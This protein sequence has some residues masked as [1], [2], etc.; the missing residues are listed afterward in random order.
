LIVTECWERPVGPRALVGLVA[1]AIVLLVLAFEVAVRPVDAIGGSD[2]T[3]YEAYGSKILDGA[4]PYQDFPMEYPPGASLMFVL[5][6][7][8]VV[9]GGSTSGV[10]WSPP[11]VAA[12]RYYRGFTSL[13]LFLPA[14]TVVL[15]ALTL[16]AVRRPTRTVALSLA[17]IASSPL[18]LER[19]LTERFDVFPA[20]L[21]A[22]VLAVSVRGHYRLG[23]VLLG[24]SA[25]TKIYPALLLPLLVIVALRQRGA[26]EAI[27][28]AGAA[29]GTA[30]AVF[31]PFALASLPA[32]WDALTV[33]FRGGL[34]I[35]TFASSVLVMAGHAAEPLAAIGL[36]PPSPLTTQ[37]AGEGLNRA[38]LA[39]T[40]VEATKKVMN[41]LLAS[42]LCLL[43]ISLYRSKRDLRE[44]LLRY[45]AATIAIV[46]VLGTVLSPQYLVWLI[47]LVPLVGGRRGI[48]A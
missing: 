29:I 6:A 23:G 14:T 11:N 9:A 25:A 44:E 38:D 19:V 48:A 45:A 33:Q 34:Q 18:L 27:S 5:P 8:S 47:P 24:L 39:G 16:S 36:P 17:V 28:V 32:T 42:A 43:Y 10:S 20:A 30:A 21:T 26:R 46:L 22:A 35:E 4:L 40:G 41:V 1:A 15:T 37:G 2:V 13:A 3:G 7:T 12:R 31:L